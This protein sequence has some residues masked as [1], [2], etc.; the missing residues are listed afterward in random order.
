MPAPRVSDALAASRRLPRPAPLASKDVPPAGELA[1]LRRAYDWFD[2]AR[3]KGSLTHSR[4]HP[5]E[6]AEAPCWLGF[7]DEAQDW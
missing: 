2:H 5:L 6:A 7:G 3:V 1:R 4:A